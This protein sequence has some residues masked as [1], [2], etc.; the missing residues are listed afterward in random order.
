MEALLLLV[1]GATNILCFMVGARVGQKVEKGEEVKLPSVNP[2]E[3]IREHQ[4]KKE[5]QRE[6]DAMETILHNI[7][8]YDGTSN[9]QKEVPWR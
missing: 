4:E 9:G 8:A 5:A 1:M 6:Q 3:A 7:E 2:L